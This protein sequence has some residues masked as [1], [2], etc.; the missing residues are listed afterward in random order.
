MVLDC[1]GELEVRG[2]DEIRMEKNGNSTGNP[3]REGNEE[4]SIP[5]SSLRYRYKI[6]LKLKDLIDCQSLPLPRLLVD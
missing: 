4:T 5:Y 3:F 2:E 1:L 6:M